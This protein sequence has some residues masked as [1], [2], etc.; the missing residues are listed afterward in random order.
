M[1]ITTAI[2]IGAT[3]VTLY[4]AFLFLGFA[5]KDKN[6]KAQKLEDKK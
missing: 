1:D 2:I 5:L 3:A 6:I 4:V